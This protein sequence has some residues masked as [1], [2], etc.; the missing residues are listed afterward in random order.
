MGFADGMRMGMAAWD[1]AQE[2]KRRKAIED[3]AEQQ[4]L[5]LEKVATAQPEQSQGFTAEQGD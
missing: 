5:E 4:R 2:D 1:S 3:R